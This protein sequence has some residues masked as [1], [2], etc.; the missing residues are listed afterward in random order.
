MYVNVDY[1]I[2][3]CLAALERYPWIALKAGLSREMRRFGKRMLLLLSLNNRNASCGTDKSQLLSLN[4]HHKQ[5]LLQLNV[6][7]LRV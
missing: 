5:L 2:K 7:G 6:K 4:V 1:V 3:D